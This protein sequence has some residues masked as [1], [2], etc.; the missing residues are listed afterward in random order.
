MSSTSTPNMALRMWYRIRV[1]DTHIVETLSTRIFLLINSL[2][3]NG[4][5]SA[6]GKQ[7]LANTRLYHQDTEPQQ[8]PS[9]ELWLNQHRRLSQRSPEEGA[10]IV[11][12][13]QLETLYSIRIPKVSVR[14]E[15]LYHMHTSMRYENSTIPYHTLMQRV[16]WKISWKSTIK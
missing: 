6:P 14:Y 16:I 4:I 10:W 5:C 3:I 13:R 9:G 1:C 7:L 8:N 11:Q 2:K 12:V 15:I